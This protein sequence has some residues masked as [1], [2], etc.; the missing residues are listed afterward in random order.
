MDRDRRWA[1]TEKAYRA[2]VEGTALQV[3]SAKDA[4]SSAYARGQTDEFIEPTLV[5]GPNGPLAPINTNDAVIFFNYRID[6]AKQLTISIIEPHFENMASIDLGYD[7]KSNKKLE[8]KDTGTT[9][10][11]NKIPGN[12]F[13]V[14]MTEYQK[15]LPVSAIAFGP[16]QV[17]MPFA[18]VLA[19]ANLSHMHMAESE[20]ERFVTYFFNGQ[21]EEPFPGESRLIVPSP[22]VPTYD[23]KPEMSLPLLVKELQKQIEKDRYHFFVVNFANADM[24]G[25]TGNLKAA[26]KGVEAIDKYLGDLHQTVMKHNGT[27]FMTADHGNAEEMLAFPSQTFFYTTAKGSVSTDHS[28][29][30]V[31]FLVMNNALLNAQYEL[32]KGELS[33]VAPTILSHMGLSVP[34]EMTGRNLL[35]EAKKSVSI[36]ASPQA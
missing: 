30:P 18:E 36:P 3:S 29:N 4:I 31:P 25:H 27:I 13:F 10:T 17:K 26:I 22:K 1:R 19:N 21:R 5:A 34:Q 35:G 20:K 7:P 33:D 15:K 24:V 16:E 6:R 12:I 28:S 23:L 2:I 9:F 8:A 14:T 11:R 32:P